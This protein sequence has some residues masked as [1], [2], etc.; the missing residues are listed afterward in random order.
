MSWRYV[1]QRP[2]FLDI[3]RA[4]SFVKLSSRQVI[5]DQIHLLWLLGREEAPGFGNGGGEG[6]TNLGFYVSLCIF[7]GAYGEFIVFFSGG[8]YD[9]IVI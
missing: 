3:S 4:R 8:F 9:F 2:N 1:H 6:A 7:I 5:P